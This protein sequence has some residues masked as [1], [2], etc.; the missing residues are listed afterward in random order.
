MG[1]FN[2]AQN[3]QKWLFLTKLTFGALNTSHRCV[4]NI[5]HVVLYAGLLYQPFWT[6]KIQQSRQAGPGKIKI[7]HTWVILMGHVYQCIWNQTCNWYSMLQKMAVLPLTTGT[8]VNTL[9]AGDE[10][11]TWAPLVMRNLAH[12]EKNGTLPVPF[13]SQREIDE[14]QTLPVMK[15]GLLQN[16]HG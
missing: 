16:A 10:M 4:S 14:R 2:S 6:I 12:Q 9:P 3:G 15:L 13:L 5:N 8:M 1:C 11:I 7:W